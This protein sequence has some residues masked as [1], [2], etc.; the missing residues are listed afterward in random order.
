MLTVKT[1]IHHKRKD[2]VKT[3]HFN[4]SFKCLNYA[5]KVSKRKKVV[6]ANVYI[7]NDLEYIYIKG[8]TLL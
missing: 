3:K 6:S 4:N 5:E 1:I 2:T 7:G 8:E